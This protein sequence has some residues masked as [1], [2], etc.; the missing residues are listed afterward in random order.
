MNFYSILIH[1]HSGLRWLALVFLILAIAD[2]AVK[3]RR[4]YDIGKSRPAFHLPAMILMHI[5]LLVGL[6]LYF[7]S[8]KVVFDA[9]SMKD[10]VLRF[11]LVEHIALMLVAI[12]LITVGYVKAKKKS[13]PV[14]KNRTLLIYYAIGLILILVSIPWPFRGLGAG[15]F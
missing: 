1:I 7:I 14:K 8:P 12:I 6:V 13:D 15:W 11:Y 10:T 4:R 2:A 3:M 9:S 5:Q